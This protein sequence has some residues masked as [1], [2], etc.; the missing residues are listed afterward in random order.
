VIVL[1]IPLELME[2][3]H[4]AQETQ[5]MMLNLNYVYVNQAIA[6]SMGFAF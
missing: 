4:D 6:M 3:V 1:K 2:F 5:N